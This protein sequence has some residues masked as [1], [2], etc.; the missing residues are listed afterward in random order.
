MDPNTHCGYCGCIYISKEWPRYCVQC[1][2]TTWRNP[3][4]VACV[5]V[6]V[7]DGLLMV[8]R[9][10]EPGLGELALPGGYIDMGEDFRVACVRELWEETG[11]V[12]PSDDIVLTDVKT[13]ERSILMFGLSVTTFT[14]D[15]LA[16]FVPNEETQELVVVNEPVETAF[17][18]HTEAV[19]EFFEI[20]R[21]N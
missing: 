21:F 1:K 4:P 15:D 18:L 19:K 10:I 20:W 14:M 8:R 6:Q 13:S 11:L 7:D 17:P 2:N 12:V 5:F 3:K 9:G 16:A